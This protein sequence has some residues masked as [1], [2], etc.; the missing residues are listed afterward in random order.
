MADPFTLTQQARL[1]RW[2]LERGLLTQDEIGMALDSDAATLSETDLTGRFRGLFLEGRLKDHLQQALHEDHESASQSR[3]ATLGHSH[4]SLSERIRV[5]SA[6]SVL[7]PEDLEA[8]PLPKGSRF[9]PLS[10]LGDG[11]MG[12][13]YK[14]FDQQ[15]QRVVALKFLKRL[16]PGPLERFIQEG[17]AQA[18]IEHPNVCN[19]YSVD[20]YDEQP[21]LSMRFIDGP[22]LKDALPQLSLEQKAGIIQAVAL[23]LHSCHRLGIIH[24]DIKPT[25]IMLERREDGTWWPYLM[26][27]GLARELGNEGMTVPGLLLGTPIY[28]SPE[29]VQGRMAEV[30]RRSD[31]YSLGATFYECL[32]GA[33]PFLSTGSLLDL[34]QRISQEDPEPLG[35]RFPHLP[36]DL[37]TIVMKTLEKDPAHRY[38]SARAL[39]EDLQRFLDG[40]PILAHSASFSYRLVKRYRKH[41]ALTLVAAG[42]TVLVLAFAGFGITMTLR[43]RIQTQSA[44]A[45]GQEAEHLEAI[46]LKAYNLPLHDVRPERAMVQERLDRIQASLGNLG[47]WSRPAAHQALGRGFLALDRLEEARRELEAATRSF[48]KDP[49]TALALGLTLAR[50]YQAELEGLRG[51]ALED[52]K[53]DC[54][55]GLRQPALACLR[56]AQGAHQDGPAFV[57]GMLALVEERH[58]DA[59]AK[60]QEYQRL[61]PWAYEAWI[62]EADAHRALAAQTFSKG[63]FPAT[64]QRLALAG[65][66]LV[67]ARGVARSAPLAYLAEVQRRMVVFQMRLDRGRASAADRDWA[68]EA[69]TLCLQANPEDWKALSYRAAIHR[70]WGADLLNRG[71]DPGSNLDLAIV[72]AEEGLK[73]G[74]R[75]NPL[76]NNLG[77]ALRNKAEWEIRQGA[78]PSVTLA[79]AVAA[80][81]QA[82]ERPQFKDWLLNSIG[83]GYLSL[84]EYQLNHGQDPTAAARNAETSLTQAAALR[85]WVGHATVLGST[86]QLLGAYQR[87][88]GRDPLPLLA[89]AHQAFTAA[90]A[91]NSH[92]F[93]A[94]LGMAGLLLDQ[95]E[96]NR[97]GSGPAT[98]ALEQ[99]LGHLAEA[100]ALNPSLAPT[101]HPLQARA[102]ALQAL[103]S[104]A[105]SPGRAQAALAARADLRKAQGVAGQDP[106]AAQAMAEAWLLLEQATPRTGA[107]AVGLKALQPALKAHP[108]AGQGFLTQG[109]LLAAL[110]RRGEALAAFAKAR[111]LNANLTAVARFPN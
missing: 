102:H 83:C 63:D 59:I 91:I 3:H 78:D 36:Q 37:Q 82:L 101:I 66:A 74:P 11:G 77:S 105:G 1:L 8:F 48:P 24:R 110:D 90:L 100:L 67:R 61:A 86:Y 46:L 54:E 22:T 71:Q 58:P 31:V 73:Y 64:E 38:D 6:A 42:A 5:L 69:T 68:L 19:I 27:F 14:A 98:P 39:A 75:E 13:V 23:A 25:N 104:P 94:Q 29:Q 76:W 55:L 53:K 50:L 26:D 87:L 20:Q 4:S 47:R 60:A 44:R 84:A 10:F 16:E 109:Q 33:P 85:P 62:L 96:A 93:Q 107:A 41:R 9:I 97:A 51:K 79:R 52:K 15:L 17:R 45:F 32:S 30:D 80:L 89:Q 12:R 108:W 72:A 21:Y 28:C 7:D 35:K 99:A 70:R 92:S 103:A 2:A 57:E 95:A 106:D 18:Q 56:R 65:D 81:Q 88:Q 49:D 34:I 43:A 111:A 40:D